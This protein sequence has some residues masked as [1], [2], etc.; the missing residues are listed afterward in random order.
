[1]EQAGMMALPH[2]CD[3]FLLPRRQRPYRVLLE[4]EKEKG[5]PTYRQRPL[6][7]IILSFLLG[8]TSSFAWLWFVLFPASLF[9]SDHLAALCRPLAIVIFL[10]CLSLCGLVA[11]G[12]LWF[13]QAWAFRT[14]IM[15][16]VLAFA[17]DLLWI[18]ISLSWDVFEWGA[19]LLL[20]LNGITLWLFLEP[21]VARAM[22]KRSH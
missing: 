17:L 19:F 22:G 21:A 10:S 16:V 4:S 15:L 1:V 7:V 6:P 9:S 14:G 12:G 11:S 5:M 2:A 13:C 3:L 18:V 20:V 8:A